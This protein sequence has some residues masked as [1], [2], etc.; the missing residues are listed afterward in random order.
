[1]TRPSSVHRKCSDR[2]SG[3]GWNSGT[4]TLVSGSTA[5][6]RSDLWRLRRGQLNQ[7]LAF[8]P[9]PPLDLGMTCST[10]SLAITSRCGL[11]HWPRRWR[12]D[13][14]TRRTRSTGRSSRGIVGER[15]AQPPSHG[16]VEGSR[17]EDQPSAIGIHERVQPRL[18]RV[19]ERPLAVPGGQDTQRFLVGLIQGRIAERDRG[20]VG[21]SF[22]AVPPRPDGASPGQRPRTGDESPSPGREPAGPARRGL[23][24]C[25]SRSWAVAPVDVTGHRNLANRLA[26]R[27]G[28]ASAAGSRRDTGAERPKRGHWPGDIPLYPRIA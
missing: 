25:P 5:W 14:R 19:R 16:H 17:L 24:G 6:V 20:A 23:P 3:R 22:E 13:S 21:Q 28:R 10:S 26:R 8:S 15:R 1:M 12:A 2:R 4:S 11:R 7:R 9:V 27:H 18:L